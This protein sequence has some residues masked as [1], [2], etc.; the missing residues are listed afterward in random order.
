MK[1]CGR[2][3]LMIAVVA[4]LILSAVNGS[5]QKAEPRATLI[6]IE[7]Q[8]IYGPLFVTIAGPEKKITDQAQEAWVINGGRHVAYS[9]SEGA[10]GFENEGQ[11]LHLY[12][13]DSGKHKQIMSEYFMV[14]TVNEVVTSK[15]K[16][17]LV[18]EM[19]DG[20]LGA[21]YIAVV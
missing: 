15:K 16:R 2:I 17:A 18:V 14:D 4:L 13:V 10:G 9:S 7:M 19:L 1:S 6:R 20:G 8:G 12:E 3:K 11:S 21:S 5:A